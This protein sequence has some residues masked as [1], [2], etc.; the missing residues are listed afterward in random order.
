MRP[1]V[2]DRTAPA[3][4]SFTILKEPAH[5]LLPDNGLNLC[6]VTCRG[7]RWQ[8]ST[9]EL[10]VRFAVRVV[11][12]AGARL[13][14]CQ[15]YT[16][17]PDPGTPRRSL[18]ASSTTVSPSAALRSFQECN[19]EGGC[20]G[21]TAEKQTSHTTGPTRRYSPASGITV[22]PAH[23]LACDQSARKIVSTETIYHL[24]TLKW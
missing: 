4:R 9:P 18:P 12:F 24:V 7:E 1:H 21:S 5:R 6:N 10:G 15:S 23:I 13:E 8:H 22:I 14:S 2:S 17:E 20:D 3:R 19:A 11:K 16:V